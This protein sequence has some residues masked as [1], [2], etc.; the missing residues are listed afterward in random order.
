MSNSRYSKGAIKYDLNP[1]DTTG[2]NDEDTEFFGEKKNARFQ[3]RSNNNK[4]GIG[5]A[6]HKE[7]SVDSLIKRFKKSMLESGK[8][9]EYAETQFFEKPSILARK[10]KSNRRY[11]AKLASEIT[12]N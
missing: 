2:M 10:K 4:P 6:L 5:V 8:M 7:E 12:N 9:K 1:V 3:F 11:K